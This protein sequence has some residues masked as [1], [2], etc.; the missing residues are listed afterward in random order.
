MT[1]K[2][3]KANATKL[4]NKAR[5]TLGYDILDA[6]DLTLGNIHYQIPEQRAWFETLI[7]AR[8]ADSINHLNFYEDQRKKLLVVT[9][10]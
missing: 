10:G 1:L 9:Q 3:K 8:L 7:T 5:T 6:I 4:V 2:A